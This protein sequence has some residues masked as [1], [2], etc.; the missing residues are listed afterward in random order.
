[1]DIKLWLLCSLAG[2]NI[3]R[4][5]DC[6]PHHDHVVSKFVECIMKPCPHLNRIELGPLGIQCW[7]RDGNGSP[8]YVRFRQLD[9]HLECEGFNIITFEVVL[10]WHLPVHSVSNFKI[11]VQQTGGVESAKNDPNTSENAS[12]SSA[13]SGIT[14]VSS[15][16]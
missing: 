5:A 7:K 4:Q 6:W 8:C 14:G 11:V 9:G 3:C 12:S 1:M 15:P 2:H 13:S 10:S 16:R